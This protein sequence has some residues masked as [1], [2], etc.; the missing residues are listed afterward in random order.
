MNA[1]PV[2]LAVA[3]LVQISCQLL[4]VVLYSVIESRGAFD[5]FVSAGG[6]PSSHSA[7]VTSLTTAVALQTGFTSEVTAVAAVLSIIVIYD[8]YRLR[9]QVEAQAK[10]I[11]RIREEQFPGEPPLSERV[12]H[13]LPEIAAGVLFG[14]AAAAILTPMLA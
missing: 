2:A 14:S 7:F 9:G 3:I 8:A 5:Y 10:L 6:F 13:T 1:I 12:G 11:N 4:K